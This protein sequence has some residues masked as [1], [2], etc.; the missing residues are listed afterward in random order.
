MDEIMRNHP[1]GAGKCPV[2][3]KSPVGQSAHEEPRPMPSLPPAKD[4]DMTSG[5]GDSGANRIPLPKASSAP[6]AHSR[7]GR[8]GISVVIA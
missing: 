8:R 7:G 2:I 4:L 1:D 3:E 5:F 6:R